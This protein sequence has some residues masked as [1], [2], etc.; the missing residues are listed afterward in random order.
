MR[1]FA[2]Y[3]LYTSLGHDELMTLYFRKKPIPLTPGTIR[4]KYVSVI[5]L[6]LLPDRRPAHC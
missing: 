5:A 4:A 3:A 6:P 1:F 2:V